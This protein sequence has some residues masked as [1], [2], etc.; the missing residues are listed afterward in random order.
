MDI[1]FE[2]LNYEVISEEASY[3]AS[4]IF[5]DRLVTKKYDNRVIEI[6]SASNLPQIPRP[7]IHKLKIFM[8][9]DIYTYVFVCMR[10]I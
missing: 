6:R 4:Y 3:E 5:V 10:A 2:E 8:I 7:Y 1:F 9:F